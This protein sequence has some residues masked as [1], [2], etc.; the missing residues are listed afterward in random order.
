MSEV[1]VQAECYR[2]IKQN[3]EM[4]A[5]IVQAMQK[6]GVQSVQDMFTKLDEV[7]KNDSTAE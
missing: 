2:L 1:E 5:I 7:L 3:Q 4:N 6:L